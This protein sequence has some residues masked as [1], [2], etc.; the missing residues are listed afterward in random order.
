MSAQDKK[1]EFRTLKTL[2][3]WLAPSRPFKKKSRD[4]FSTIGAIALLMVIILVFFQEWLLIMVIIAMTFAAYVLATIQPEEVKHRITNRGL[5]TGGKSY[6]W[7]ELSRF[8]FEKKSGQ[9]ILYVETKLRLPRLLIL[10][11]G[12]ADQAKIKNLLV[13]N[14][15][16]EKPEKTW[17][18]K[19]GNWLSRK[20]P[21]E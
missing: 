20:F 3:V 16:L 6:K 17:L 9:E 7:N 12:G 13:D 19:A 18:D 15:P 21:L 11:L 5:V 1:T 8:W 4:F 10:L 2:L 14:L